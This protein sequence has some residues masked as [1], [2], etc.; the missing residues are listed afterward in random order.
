VV[1]EAADVLGGLDAVVN[2]AG[3][4]HRSS[5]YD[6]WS[7]EDWNQLVTRNLSIA[8]FVTQAAVPHLEAAGG[9]AIV[10]ISSSASIYPV[11]A[12]TPY[13]AAKAGINNLTMTLAR[14]LGPRGV[15]INAVA[16]GPTKAGRTWRTLTDGGREPTEEEMRT[17]SLG[18][19]ADVEEQAW[20]IVFLLSDAAGFITGTTLHVDG[21][22][23]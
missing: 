13:G 7:V 23:S 17:T 22:H 12:V 21:A 15:R 4:S 8:F 5:T 3:G 11:P 10:S 14:E 2:A 16:P 6:G 1:D 9:G 18:R 20:P 19:M